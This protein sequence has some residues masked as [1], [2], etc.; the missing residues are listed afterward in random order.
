M[1][2]NFISFSSF[3]PNAIFPR[4]M[5]DGTY[6][7]S[8]YT[9]IKSDLTYTFLSG[10]SVFVPEDYVSSIT[11]SYPIQGI[12]FQDNNLTSG[13]WNILEFS[14][15]SAKEERDV[16]VSANLVMAPTLK[17]IHKSKIEE[18]LNY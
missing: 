16:V 4:D 2:P 18:D 7:L 13:K 3:S 17:I 5:G 9:H 14:V 12:R 6:L 1:D 15:T 8:S 11:F 10:I